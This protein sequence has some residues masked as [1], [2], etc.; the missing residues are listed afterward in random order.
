M[1][2]YVRDHSSKTSGH[3]KPN[4]EQNEKNRS[5]SMPHVMMYKK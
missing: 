4:R 3:E 2:C 1:R 5:L